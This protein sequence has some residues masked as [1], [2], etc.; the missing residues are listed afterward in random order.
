MFNTTFFEFHIKN[1]F[2]VIGCIFTYFFVFE[3]FVYFYPIVK[4]SKVKLDC[5]A[6]AKNYILENKKTNKLDIKQLMM[7]STNFCNGGNEI[8]EFENLQD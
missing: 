8:Y 5:Q 4:N 7:L 1:I 3:G 2:Q 6:V